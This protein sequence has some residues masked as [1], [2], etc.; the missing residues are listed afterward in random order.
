MRPWIALYKT[1]GSCIYWHHLGIKT[2][3]VTLQSYLQ[4]RGDIM[5][6]WSKHPHFVPLCGNYRWKRFLNRRRWLRGSSA[7][8]LPHMAGAS[9][10]KES[11][12]PKTSAVRRWGMF[13]SHD[14]LFQGE[15]HCRRAQHFPPGHVNT[16]WL[17]G[18]LLILSDQNH[19]YN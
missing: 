9:A 7:E 14:G 11:Q 12:S 19:V 15:S 16:L 4:S 8:A 17:A 18:W 1:T 3:A 13:H 2:D 5:N 6:T 10:G